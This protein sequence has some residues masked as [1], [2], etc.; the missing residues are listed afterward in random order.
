[1]EF[2]FWLIRLWFQNH[3]QCIFSTLS[4]LFLQTPEN[5]LYECVGNNFTFSDL[6]LVKRISGWHQVTGLLSSFFFFSFKISHRNGMFQGNHSSHPQ[7]LSWDRIP[8]SSDTEWDWMCK[9]QKI[10]SFGH[11]S[12]NSVHRAFCS[13]Q[14]AISQEILWMS[15]FPSVTLPLLPKRTLESHSTRLT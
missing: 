1:M 14:G 10:G 4:L 7:P 11:C 6:W 8:G 12:Q 5:M 3:R 9:W 2:V 13:K 15:V